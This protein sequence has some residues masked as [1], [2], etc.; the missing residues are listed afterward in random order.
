MSFVRARWALIALAI[1]FSCGAHSQ[2]APAGAGLRLT[3]EQIRV[4]G[5]RIA[6]ARGADASRDKS[7]SGMQ[8]DGRVVLPGDHP[9]TVLSAVTGQLEAQFVQVGQAVRP[10]MP[11]LRI[12]SAELATLQR[13][14]LHAHAA[15]S[16]AES[17]VKRDETLF[18]EG[19]IAQARLNETHAAY[20]MAIAT[21]QE[22]RRALLLAGYSEQEV[23]ALRPESISATLTVQARVAG[24]V[25]EQPL[26]AGQHIEVGTVLLRLAGPGPWW[27]DLQ[28]SSAQVRDLSVGDAVSVPGCHQP[29]RVI[30]IGSQVDPASQ[31]VVVR[32]EVPEPEKCL[33]VNQYVQTNISKGSV[34]AGWVSVPASAVVRHGTR[35]FVFVKDAE[36]FRPVEISVARR[37]GTNAWL[38]AGIAAGTEVAISGTAALKGA[39]LGLGSQAQ[40]QP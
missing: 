14:Y 1:G 10:G 9:G 22:Q 19:I 6:S 15:T 40:G 30:A 17:R 27:I 33:R 20:Q 21:E 39:W 4:A 13:E 24:V 34:P 28:A 11:L 16:L 38:S 12:H 5:I 31:T 2:E 32:A 35:E 18:K 23:Q 29:G 3:P 26:R 25:S 37:D 7:S 36:R 8:L